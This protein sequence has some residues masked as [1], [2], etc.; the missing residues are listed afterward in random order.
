[1]RK[2]HGNENRFGPSFRPKK[3][4]NKIT[5]VVYFWVV[6]CGYYCFY[7]VFGTVLTEREA[8]AKRFVDVRLQKGEYL[9]REVVEES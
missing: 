7:L 8:R 6:S 9:N 4:H 3:G 1:M 2:Q 5:I